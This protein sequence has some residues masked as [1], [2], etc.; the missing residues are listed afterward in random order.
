[1]ITSMTRE[2]QS[3]MDLGEETLPEG[4]DS[5]RQVQSVGT[6]KANAPYSV[7]YRHLTRAY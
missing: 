4:N 2:I 7:Q 1:M 6:M 3:G 5:Y